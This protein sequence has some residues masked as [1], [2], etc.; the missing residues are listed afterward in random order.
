MGQKLFNQR[1]IEFK[2]TINKLHNLPKPWQIKFIDG[3]DQRIWFDKIS[4]IAEYS[5][6]TKEI[7]ILLLDYDKKILTDKDKEEEF[8]ECITVLDRIPMEREEYFSDN[9]DMRRWYNSYKNNNQSYAN[10][11]INIL[12]EVNDLDLAEIWF[13]IKEEF[14]YIIKKVKRIPNYNEAILQNGIDVRIICDKLEKFDPLAWERLKLHLAIY[15]KKRILPITRVKELLNKISNLGY[16]P[17]LQEARFSDGCDMFTW[18]LTYK[19]RVPELEMEV[20]RIINTTNP[21]TKQIT[22]K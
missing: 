16:I 10:K 11:I 19:K 5:A 4:K 21:K 8:F 9:S 13:D 14:K 7:E 15:D 22:R 2:E 12:T 1:K 18:Y 20:N 3:A 6:Y 17:E